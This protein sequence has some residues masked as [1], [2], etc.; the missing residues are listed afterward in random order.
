MG[1]FKQFCVNLVD[2]RGHRH[3]GQF[4][5][6]LRVLIPL[7]NIFRDCLPQASDQVSFFR[8]TLWMTSQNAA[9]E[10]DEVL[11]RTHIQIVKRPDSR[12]DRGFISNL[13]NENVFSVAFCVSLPPKSVL[14]GVLGVRMIDFRP[15]QR[16]VAHGLNGMGCDGV[17]LRTQ[18]PDR[19]V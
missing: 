2:G 16:D 19:P 3:A 1:D 10:R 4:S 6:R 8:L 12:Q 7:F 14:G 9:L 18:L 5:V 13:S 15:R 11:S 17:R